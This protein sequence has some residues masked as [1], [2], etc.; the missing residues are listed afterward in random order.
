MAI[1]NWRHK[2]NH[3]HYLSTAPLALLANS[4]R[5]TSRCARSAIFAAAAAGIAVGA[6][7]ASAHTDALG[8]LVSD[9]SAAGLFNVQIIYGSW[10]SGIVSAE[11]AVQ[12]NRADSST[13]GTQAFS[14]LLS[15]APDGAL[16]AGLTPGQNFFYVSADG[17]SLVSTPNNAVYNFQAATFNDVVTGTYTFAYAST[18][19]LTQVWTP[20]GNAVSSGTFTVTSNG[21][22]TVP[23]QANDIDTA[24][25]SYGS[26]NLGTSVNPSF[27][28]GTLLIDQVD[29]TYSNNFSLD[30][31]ATNTLDMNGNATVLSGAFSDTAAGT[32]GVIT[33]EDSGSGGQVTLTGPGTYTGTTTLNSGTLILAGT[34]TLGA[35]GASTIV[36]G[37]TLDLG[38]TSQV[39]ASVTQAGGIIENGTFTVGTYTL[40]G[41]TLA[42]GAVIDTAATI[43]AQAGAVDGALTGTAGLTK[44]GDGT[45]TLASAN[46]YTGGTVVD[47]G[48]LALS[49]TG[50]LGSTSGTT[51]LNG[52]TLDLGST[53][54]TQ[55]SLTQT[56]GTV[57]NGTFAVGSYTLTGGTLASNSVVNADN[58][59]DVQVGRINGT[60]TGT[61]GLAK[62]GTDGVEL[63][64]A[65]SYTGNT[66]IEDGTLALSGAGTLGSADGS[67]TINRGTLDLGG[68][69]Q[70]Q[71]S[72]TQGSA[73]ILNGTLTLDSYTM[74]N[75]TLANTVVA[76][77]RDTID[78]ESGMIAG[79]LTGTA[80][81]TK[82]GGGLL[83]LN[84]ANNYSGGTTVNGGS[85]ALGGSGS[86]ISSV[87]VGTQ[88]IFDISAADG[89][90]ALTT[91]T[92]AGGIE[93][94]S[95]T[96]T[97]TQASGAYAGLISGAGGLILSAQQGYALE[98]ASTYSGGTSLLVGTLSLGHSNALGTGTLAMSEFTAIN[99][100]QSDMVIGNAITVS[101]DPTIDVATGIAAT[102]AGTI[103]DGNEPGDIVKTGGG[104]LIFTG[105]NT[106][107]AG[108]TISGGTLQLG[109]GGTSGAIVGNVLN[110]AELAFN[111]SDVVTFAS[112]I[113]GTGAVAQ[114]GTGTTTFTGV[115]TYSG[116]TTIS[117]GTLIGSV[118]SFGSGAILNNSVLAINQSTDANFANAVNGTGTFNKQ[119]AGV[120]TLTGT[121]GLSGVTNVAQ[122]ELNVMGSLAA[123]RVTLAGGTK[124]SGT[125][126]VGG[127]T[128]SSGSTIA[129]GG[130]TVGTLAVNG[131]VAQQ[132]NSTYAVQVT[133]GT[134]LSD[135]IAVSGA[136]ALANGAALVVV[137]TNP[138]T[139][140][141]LGTRYTV[142]T[143]ANGVAG[144]YT[145]TGDTAVSA[146]YN[147][148]AG[149]DA[150]NIYLDVAQ[151]SSFVSAGTT[152]NERSVAGALDALD[153][154]V[155]LRNALG[156]V[157]TFEEARGAF[158]Q[159]SGEIHSS[160][161]SALIQDS[162]YLRD[163]VS[164]RL[165]SEI[166]GKKAERPGVSIWGNGY[167][168]WGSLAGNGNAGV[169]HRSARGLLAGADISLG[170]TARGGVMG[171]YSR[172][173][174]NTAQ[175]RDSGE[176]DNYHLGAYAGANV[177]P[178]NLQIGAAYTWHKLNIDRSVLF[179]GFSDDLASRYNGNTAQVFGEAGYRIS[180]NSGYFEPFA[181]VSHVSLHTDA[182]TERG[183]D[184]ALAG[185]SRKTQV[186]FSTLG[187]R[188]NVDVANEGAL[189]L[190]WSTGWRRAFGNR[191]PF[192]DMHFDAGTQVFGIAGAPLAKNA[193]ALQAG[194]EASVASGIS[195]SASYSG[196]TG[197]NV[198]DHGVKGNLTWRF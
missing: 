168:S 107:S 42:S 95:N 22:V 113:S 109:N 197:R 122:G 104:T 162:Q 123:S 135:R 152:P 148:V 83:T 93:L 178:L 51:T 48:T 108:T 136:A 20:A 124:L 176:S 14:I 142:L 12:L 23:G 155:G 137:R 6:N 128:A 173:K 72:L 31:T 76:D 106:Y 17:N 26:S 52:G 188:G 98:G 43:D 84:S 114:T 5:M 53:S 18:S 55:T 50:T 88:G 118:T 192:T 157:Q 28:G 160:A 45:V 63:S 67:T 38:G 41:G 13:V 47:A 33:Y 115:N 74:L 138:G 68:T 21:G 116:G 35:D 46:D 184:A 29:Q 37:G 92:G 66:V 11:G 89:D 105:N 110:N 90:R 65:N 103:A 141:A 133:A 170:D 91:M 171:G 134:S 125:G 190:F 187:L 40:T 85:L 75:G 32:P 195:I 58:T 10:H 78:A 64:G 163:A 146:F 70:I 198:Q 2:I 149:Y 186:T 80:S 126:I 96:L 140:Y 16:P 174:F 120:V 196:Q 87:A 179:A 151:T 81:L 130:A 129:P 27:T 59:I 147:L 61:A 8:Y 69:S 159:L 166:D 183:G 25:S 73:T 144:T 117:E 191:T 100:T 49:G 9:G 1:R 54:Q 194:I 153:A 111:R 7:V 121:S 99:L 182:F 86:I 169:L 56:G 132:A 44:S 62:T 172:S 36:N 3:R 185:R 101:G 71:A 57:Q 24:N 175:H 4:P 30:S 77:V 94:G 158:R 112:T 60:L 145:L 119:G 150:R 177:G 79:T 82:T 143:T 102:V 193:A 97:L 127:I 34:A 180:V 19:G 181:Q 139:R 39:Q 165:L 167:G 161:K 189:R 156:Y 15:N 131:N 164:A 154:A